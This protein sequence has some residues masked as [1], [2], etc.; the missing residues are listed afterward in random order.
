M[1]QTDPIQDQTDGDE[2][3]LYFIIGEFAKK[4]KI[5]F[6]TKLK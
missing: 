4:K 5:Y 6:S 2:L 1:L 3:R